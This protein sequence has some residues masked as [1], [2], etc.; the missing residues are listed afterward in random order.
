M[1]YR[2]TDPAI[3]RTPLDSAGPDL[4]STGADLG[5]TGAD[6]GSTGAEAGAAPWPTTP[7]TRTRVLREGGPD[8]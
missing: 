8:R 4:G 6:L 3:R 7:A 2:C 5:S 1:R